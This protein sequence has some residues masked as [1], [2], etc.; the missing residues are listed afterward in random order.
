VIVS[1]WARTGWNVVSP[2]VLIDATATRNATAWQQLRGR[3]MRPAPSWSSV[4]QRLVQHLLHDDLNDAGEGE[5]VSAREGGLHLSGLPRDEAELAA[6]LFGDMRDG[7]EDS[8]SR[9][10]MAVKVMLAINKVTHV[11]ELVR[12]YGTASQVEYSRATR[13]WER[14]SAIAAKHSREE[15]VRPADGAYIAGPRHAP[16]I[17]DSDPRHD[18]PNAFKSR[19][20]AE[21][22]SADERI[23]Q[24]W[25]RAAA[26]TEDVAGR[27]S[28]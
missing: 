12:A 4:A 9:D 13:R 2:N 8:R 20:A 17:V 25:L 3:A 27:A 5:T 10:A 1:D 22:A 28:H 24:G 21:L 7:I 16:L 26:A 19:L 15:G 11:Y 6:R 14:S 23:V 18:R